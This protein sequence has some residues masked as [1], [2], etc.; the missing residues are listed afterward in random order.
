M[1]KITIFPS[2]SSH[3]AE[4]IGDCQLPM[5]Y[6]SDFSMMGFVVDRYSDALALLTS[7]GYSLE[8]LHSGAEITIQTHGD[9]LAI[10]TLF[11]DNL[12]HCNYTDIVDSLYQA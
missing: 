2:G 11:A 7:S 4:Y 1:T 12:I 10:Q 9:L 3:R 8:K 6:M 5:N